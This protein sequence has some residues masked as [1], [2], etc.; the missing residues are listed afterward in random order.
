M[1][2]DQLLANK[3][4]KIIETII[5][6][7]K[8]MHKC[9]VEKKYVQVELIAKDIVTVGK[10]LYPIFEGIHEE[11]P[12]ISS[13]IRCENFIYSTNNIIRLVRVRSD[14]VL[15]KIEF[16][17][18]T[19]LRGMYD[20]FYFF[21]C[22]FGNKEREKRYY[23]EEFNKAESNLY[24][25]KSIERNNYK[26]DLTIYVCA[27]N[28]LEY[29]K[30]CIESIIKYTPSS[31][32]YELVLLNNGS[33][34]DTQAYFD[35]LKCNKEISF[36]KNV[37]ADRGANYTFE[38]RYVLAVTNDV[39]V[40]ENYLDNLLKCMESDTKIVMVVPT[41]PNISNLQTIPAKYS[42]LEEMHSFAKQNNVSNPKLWEE[43]T[44]L[45]NPIALFKSDILYSTR[46]V[47]AV[48]KYFIYS[49]FGD[50]A[51]A[52]RLRRAGYKMILAKDC[53]CYHFGSVTLGEA[54]VK[55]NT[56]EKSRK[57]FIDRYGIDAWGT[58]FCYDLKLM[59]TLII[60]KNSGQVNILGV[61]SGFG[62]NPLKIKTMHRESA[63]QDIKL[64]YATDDERYIEDLKVYSDDVQYYSDSVINAY[65]DMD[66]LFNYIVL[67]DNVIN[68]MKSSGSLN[69][70][71]NKLNK[72]GILA[73]C[74]RNDKEM[75]LLNNFKP[76]KQV[77]SYG[78]WWFLW[79]RKS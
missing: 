49:E 71:K 8:H 6:S 65:D 25:D 13:S 47:G 7:A 31:L 63:S 45:C 78:C 68:I 42:T 21:A 72:D 60:K 51:L 5:E 55:E 77:D 24:I 11:L 26:Y 32:N 70:L 15:Y 43:R 27:Y 61:N 76:H 44:R 62:S 48:D 50:D 29:T 20:N 75:K 58:G 30:Q 53:Y 56:L 17:L 3:M 18:L 34:D 73:I 9:A 2:K 79:T 19:I 54:Q 46:G 37:R 1:L 12:F 66:I 38:G 39:I 52:L 22:V 16:E 59:E 67:E 57:L 23:L 74:A 28:K 10:E 33:S 41:T 4:L 35:S 64:Y 40:T 36:F 14:K 69:K